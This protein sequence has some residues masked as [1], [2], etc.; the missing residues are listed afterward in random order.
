[1]N[2]EMIFVFAVAGVAAI[3]MASN[4]VRYDI[5]ALGVV[6]AL[7]L[8][9]I[10]T[11]GQSI[12]GFG[13]SV[14]MLVAALLVVGE[15]LDR[16]GVARAVGDV[17]L[18]KGGGSET[19]LLVLIM[20]AAAVLGGVMS[21]TAIV[22]VFI[23]I[24]VRIAAS[25]GIAASRLLM[26]MSYAALISGMLTL[27][28]TTPNIVMTEELKGSGI[29][30]FGF[31]G[32]TPVGVA[33]LIA[34]VIYML[35][36]GRHLLPT[37]DRSETT[38]DRGRSIL[39]LWDEYGIGESHEILR[40]GDGNPLVG[41]T[42]VE[43][44]IESG[45]GVR[46]VGIRRSGRGNANRVVAASS[47]SEFHAGDDL[48]V[49][50]DPAGRDRLV[51]E[52]GLKRGTNPPG[53]ADRWMW[54]LG[55]AR[56][57]I[58]PDS[59]LIGRSIRE[60]AFRST[61]GLQV[62]ALRR[63]GEVVD[64]HENLALQAGDSLLVA[65]PW[66]RIE[67][68]ESRRHDFVLTEIPHEQ[69]DVVQGHRKLPVAL[70]ILIAMVLLTIFNVVPLVAAVIMAAL[71]AVVTRCLSME[72]AYRSIHWS[73][74]VLVA[75]ML[76]LADAL[77]VT[78][79]T[80]LVVGTIMSTFGDAGPRAMLTVIFFLT[81]I[82]GLFLSN[83]AS[84]VLVAPVA[85]YTARS[86]DIS[87]YPFAVA[88]VIA[89]SAAFS[90]PVSTPVVTLVVEPGRYRFMDFVK[91]GVPLLLV[92]YLVTVLVAPIVFPFEG[93]EWPAGPGDAVPIAEESN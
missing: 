45:F 26:P 22:A 27:I 41:R 59:R 72:E 58:H 51:S 63:S 16:T 42:L 38:G 92:A 77:D 60:Q 61:H 24:V 90:T 35:V 40:L 57:L 15:M 91:V 74:I 2:P 32:F 89:A 81:A 28:A 48:V 66:A 10:L 75:G 25:T 46:V 78:G 64:N 55:S 53:R 65:G 30:G 18:R 34:A 83:T 33:V 19:R 50:G 67:Q 8:S 80:D 1:M 29:E 62:L 88:V 5:V 76:P 87:P 21:S 39:D 3:L 13:S 4:R 44:G 70:A 11:V 20:V 14:V 12:A 17:I 71:A 49:V 54:D 47:A 82:I 37:G 84:A 73:S 68:L 43:S 86:L 56:I 23:P 85:I 79:G 93:F 6:L 52:L 7:M 36:L 69:A 31:F 9:G